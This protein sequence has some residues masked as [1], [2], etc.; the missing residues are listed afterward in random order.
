M[1]KMKLVFIFFLA[2]I[3]AIAQRQLSSPAA[4]QQPV[5]FDISPPLRD[6]DNQ[7]QSQVDITWKDGVVRNNFNN[8]HLSGQGT[9]LPGFTDPSLQDHLGQIL[10][11][12]TIEN[13]E[14]MGASGYIP[15]DTYGDI[16][17]N[18]YFQVVNATYAIYNKGGVKLLGPLANSS[19][20][21]GMP[22]NSNNGDAVVL[23]DEKANRWLFSQFS[24]P[25]YPNGPFYQ[26]IAVSQTP[27]PTGSWYRYQY[28]FTSMPD[29][30]KFGVWTDGYYMSCNRFSA[31]SGYYS[32]TG[33][34]A[35]DRTQMIAGN[36]I[37][38][39]VW[40]TLSSS[41]EAYSILPSDCDGDFPPSGT[42]NYF[43]YEYDASPYHL[44][45]LE[46][47]ADWVTPTNSTFGNLLSLTVN[48]FNPNLGPGIPQQGTTARLATLSDRL[49]YRL[50]FRKFNSHWS[51]VCNHSVNVGANVAGIRWYE[52]RKTTGAWTVYQQA[53]YAPSDNNCRWMGSMAMDTAGN[54]AVGY[55]ISSSNM[56]PSIRYTGRMSTDPLNQ[57]TI[58]ERG[59]MNGGG[60]QTSSSHRWGDYSSMTVDPS[61]PTTFWYTTEY[62]ATTS[63]SSWHTRIASFSFTNVFSSYAI[64][65]PVKTCGGDSSQLNSV[66]YGGSGNYTYSWTSDP[67]GFTSNIKNPKVAPL[68]T[69]KYIVAV[70]DGNQT[71][72]D[73]TQ[74]SAT[75][76]PVA[77]AGN[78]TTICSYRTS[79]EVNGT[80]SNYK[81]FGWASTGDGSFANRFAF[82]T[83]YT[84]GPNDYLVGSVDLEFIAFA[85]SPCTGRVTDTAHVTL[86]PC[87]G[88]QASSTE[89]QNIILQ[90]NPARESV[91]LI[92]NGI[93]DK[94]ILIL[95]TDMKGQLLYS[96]DVAVSAKSVTQ[97]INLHGYPAGI[98]FIKV[99]TDKKVITKQLVIY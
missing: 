99:R 7:P 5:Y 22:N 59:I 71:H 75:P 39:M 50:Q 55:S 49:M 56:Y 26:M 96:E 18:H 40:F 95:L 61:S 91:T 85:I 52:L 92:I 11:D 64:A 42:P 34:A 74:V 83:T 2:G 6:M 36:P 82:H 21:T 87:T 3:S 19:V 12:T 13:F 17:P 25:N 1:K 72:Y 23:Y 46:F 48:S 81:S 15:P 4:V 53:T 93:E 45:I 62:Y 14:G 97:Q 16:G 44:G 58:T 84:F 38:Q 27:D 86:D 41:N 89:D 65:D 54:I 47:H 35:F 68:D 90:P 94:S 31:G 63:S 88:I 78:D 76:P 66:A 57:M 79:M 20:W 30:P 28:L 69:T 80:A 43:T 10:T 33:A 29:Y 98:Y 70:S 9:T 32:G 73:T 24:L 77:F 67:P 37:A 8:R 60:C 51:M